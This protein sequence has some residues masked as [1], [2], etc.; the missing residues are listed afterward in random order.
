LF[1]ALNEVI[2][3]LRKKAFGNKKPWSQY[4]LKI[5]YSNLTTYTKEKEAYKERIRLVE[6][7][8]IRTSFKVHSSH[9][10]GDRYS[11]YIESI[12]SWIDSID[13]ILND[14]W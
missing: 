13:N 14:L 7:E 10:L 3:R 9:Y 12:K 8:V 2:I 11:N 4:R 1:N 6:Q 5:E